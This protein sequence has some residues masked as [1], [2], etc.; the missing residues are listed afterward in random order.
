LTNLSGKRNLD[1]WFVSKVLNWGTR[2]KLQRPWYP[3]F[4]FGILFSS[5]SRYSLTLMIS[6][7]DPIQL[8][9]SPN[10]IIIFDIGSEH[11]STAILINSSKTRFYRNIGL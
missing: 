10:S 5:I 6:Y 1:N 3:D 8:D 9:S 11:I 4:I 7:S 2:N